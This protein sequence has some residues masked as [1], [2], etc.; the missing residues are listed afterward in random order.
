MNKELEAILLSEN[1]KKLDKVND[2]LEDNYKQTVRE[3]FIILLNA[4]KTKALIDIE[5]IMSNIETIIL[6][7]DSRNYKII[8]NVVRETNNKMQ[9]LKRNANDK[10]KK[11]KIRKDDVNEKNK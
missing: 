7:Q 5:V 10:E 6:R 1:I 9:C 2:L 3:M 11:N 4:I 8:N